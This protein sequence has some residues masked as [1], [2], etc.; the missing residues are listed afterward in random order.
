MTYKEGKGLLELGNLTLRQILSLRETQSA[1]R[2][3][4][5]QARRHPRFASM[6]MRGNQQVC[7]RPLSGGEGH[8]ENNRPWRRV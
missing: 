4:V 8:K 2:A 1:K 3:R 7:A 5:I 6:R